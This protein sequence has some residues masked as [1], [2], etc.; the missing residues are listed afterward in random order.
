MV[1]SHF[2]EVLRS[3]FLCGGTSFHAET[4]TTDSTST[5]YNSKYIKNK[6]IKKL[7]NKK[8]LIFVLFFSTNLIVKLYKVGQMVTAMKFDTS[9]LLSIDNLF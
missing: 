4:I 3:L 7:I 1:Q 8:L 2:P 5:S 6:L 9:T